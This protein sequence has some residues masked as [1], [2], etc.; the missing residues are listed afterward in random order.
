[1]AAATTMPFTRGTEKLAVNWSELNK[2]FTLMAYPNRSHSG[3]RGE[4]HNPALV[5]SAY[6]LPQTTTCP[7]VPGREEESK[8]GDK[9]QVQH[10][11]SEAAFARQ[12][13]PD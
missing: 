11:S 2:P 13:L 5:Q 3:Q 4:E 8:I 6:P 1:M 7:P 12:L 10:S 9:L